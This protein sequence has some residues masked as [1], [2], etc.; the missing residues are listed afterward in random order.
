[1]AKL[2]RHDDFR[3]VM[4]MNEWGYRTKHIPGSLHFNTP[5][6]MLAALGKNDEIV[7]YCSNVDCHASVAAYHALVDH[8]YTNVRR[9]EGGLVDWETA[10][11]RLEGE[12]APR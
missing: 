2:A 11:Q 8:G 3:L 6:D 4:T 10:G 9:Y 7:V 12:W 5:E 1:M